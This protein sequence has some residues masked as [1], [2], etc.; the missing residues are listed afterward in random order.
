M[1]R[2]AAFGAIVLVLISPLAHAAEKRSENKYVLNHI[3]AGSGKPVVL[4]HGSYGSLQDYTYSI[5]TDVAARFFAIAPDLPGHGR[6]RRVKMEMTL[7]DHADALHGLL[8]DMHVEKPV[9]VGHSWGGAV[10]LEYALK[11]PAEVSG[12]VLLG[13]Y[14]MPYDKPE[15]KYRLST[16]PFL[17][18]L[19][20]QTLTRPF[21]RFGDPAKLVEDSFKPNPPPLDYA[22]AAVAQA[23]DPGAFQATAQD[24]KHLGP[25]LKIIQSRLGEIKC[26]VIIVTGDSDAVA[27]AEQHAIPLHAKI[28]Q[29]KLIVLH[30]TG[31]QPQFAKPK[32]VVEAIS[33][34][35]DEASQQDEVRKKTTSS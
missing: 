24:I 31:H 1:R 19:F 25:G 5:F 17:G 8:R 14:T 20:V 26:P 4:I 33:L 29:S 27:P 15:F 2:S 18:T 22:K 10:V 34:A 6:S 3:S 30:G 9:L 32:E 13:A 11:Y 35:W 7:E 28:P 16:T 23:T 21:A 12:L